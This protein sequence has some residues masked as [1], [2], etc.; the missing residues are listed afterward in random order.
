[1]LSMTQVIHPLSTSAHSSLEL[2]ASYHRSAYPFQSVTC[3]D[4]ASH[5]FTSCSWDICFSLSQATPRDCLVTFS[6]DSW[7]HLGEISRPLSLSL[8]TP[9]F[10]I[11]CSDVFLLPP[12]IIPAQSC[13]CVIVLYSMVYLSKCHYCGLCHCIR[14]RL[15]LPIHTCPSVNS[16]AGD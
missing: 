10:H 14:V 9:R 15:H 16:W 6:P 4:S 2:P 1:M 5:A 13:L 12:C 11:P 7:C 8:L 3:P